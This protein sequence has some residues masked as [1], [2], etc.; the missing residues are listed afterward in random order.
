MF[1]TRGSRFFISVFLCAAFLSGCSALKVSSQ[2]SQISHAKLATATSQVSVPNTGSTSSPPSDSGA[3]VTSTPS[4]P[5]ASPPTLGNTL[6][7]ANSCDLINSY[8]LASLFPAHNEIIRD[9]PKTGPVS[10]P[11]F[12]Q[13]AAAGTQ[14]TCVFYDFHQPGKVSGW[15]LQVTYLVDTPDPSAQQAW[16][17]A[18]SANAKSGQ[19]VSDLGVEAFASG[20]NLFI[21]K[22]NTY[23]TFESVDTHLNLK[24]AAGM[25]QV[26]AYNEQLAKDGLPNL[27]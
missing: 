12:S 17:Q 11:P 15:M 3:A 21:K 26:L 9:A 18:W 6:K 22:G 24:T 5:K 4:L 14:E 2:G 16:A 1:S 8:D 19:P 27:K 10:H 23:L 25:Q 7:M 13:V 20:A